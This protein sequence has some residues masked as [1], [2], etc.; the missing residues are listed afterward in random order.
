MTKEQRKQLYK[1]LKQW[2]TCEAIARLAPIP[3]PNYGDYYYRKLELENEIRTLVFGTDD[4]VALGDQWNL[5]IRR[6]VVKQKKMEKSLKKKKTKKGKKHEQISG[7]RHTDE[8]FF[9][10][11][12]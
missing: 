8:G 12:G 1:L 2:T 9:R 4:L 6:N 3:W 5:P 10:S 7:R 11:D